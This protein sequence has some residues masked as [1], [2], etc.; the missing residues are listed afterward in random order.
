[1]AAPTA[2]TISEQNAAWAKYERVETELEQT[3]KDLLRSLPSRT[4]ELLPG[5]EFGEPKFRFHFNQRESFYKIVATGD[6]YIL[7]ESSIAPTKR[8]VMAMR[9][10]SSIYWRDELEFSS[11]VEYIDKGNE[12][13]KR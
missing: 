6:D 8:R 11:S 12:K 9:F 5:K 3:R 7:V 10:I 1:M 4:K 2:T 13:A